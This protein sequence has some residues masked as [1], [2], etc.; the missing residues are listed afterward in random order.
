MQ[1]RA[2][3]LR[4]LGH[5]S[6]APR[7]VGAHALPLSASAMAPADLAAI[8]PAVDQPALEGR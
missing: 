8:S 5:F 4:I 6:R 7:D 1:G 3:T 2:E